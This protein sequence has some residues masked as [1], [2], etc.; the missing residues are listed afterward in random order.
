ME[1]FTAAFFQTKHKV[2]SYVL[3]LYSQ[4]SCSLHA[5]V[6]ESKS[7]IKNNIILNIG[8][9]IGIIRC[10]NLPNKTKQK[11]Y[12]LDF[13]LVTWQLREHT[14]SSHC[15]VLISENRR[16]KMNMLSEVFNSSNVTLV[17]ADGKQPQ[18]QCRNF[19]NP[20]LILSIVKIP[21]CVL[22]ISCQVWFLQVWC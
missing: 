13:C 17:P 15:I 9:G 10:K 18:C 8:T 20:H 21:P 12:V 3:G 4:L 14:H 6:T 16:K 19:H 2:N 1:F 7:S 5:D 22:P 11:F